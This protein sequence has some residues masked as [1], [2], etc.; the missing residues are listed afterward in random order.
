VLRWYLDM[1]LWTLACW[2]SR[3]AFIQAVTSV[4]RFFPTYLE[5]RRQVVR[6]PR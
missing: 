4:E 6:L 1:A 3:Q 5:T 2:Q